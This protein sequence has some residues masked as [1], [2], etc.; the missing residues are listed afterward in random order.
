MNI[1]DWT[2]Q[3]EMVRFKLYSQEN[4]KCHNFGDSDQKKAFILKNSGFF[5]NKVETNHV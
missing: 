4:Q 2:S 5:E 3:H 1:L